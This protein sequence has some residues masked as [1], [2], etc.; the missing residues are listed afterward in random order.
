MRITV[1]GAG[2]MGVA[3]AYDL[4]Q[5]SDITSVVLA[6]NDL[7]RLGNAKVFLKNPNLETIVA[8]ASSRSLA[9]PAIQFSDVVLSCAPYKYNYELAN[10]A[11]QA[12][13]S[14]VD[15]GGNNDIVAKEL[16]L[17]GRAKEAGVIIIPDCGLAPGLVSILTRA[18]VDELDEVKEVHLRVGGLPQNPRGPLAYALT[19]SISGL[20][21]EYIEPVVVL[22]D[23]V[24]TI[25]DPLED[26][27]HLSI[28]GYHQLE[29]FNTSGGISTLPD[30]FEGKISELDYKTIRY[31]GHVRRI[32][33]LFE[34]GLF[35]SEKMEGLGAYN[36]P[37]QFM[38]DWLVRTLPKNKEDIIL[39]KAW[40]VGMKN[41][42]KTT[43][44]YEM[45][46]DDDKETGLTAM[47]RTTSFT[48]A[49]IVQLI[50]KGE[51]TSKGAI[52]QELCVP[53]QRVID[54]LAK[55]G[56]KI[57]KFIEQ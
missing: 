26:E 43:I 2:Q 15:L 21:N 49:T 17:N 7:Q 51:I 42:R 16:E 34:L 37:R 33:T 30:T 22:R 35:D 10:A 41:G 28:K 19:F 32:K 27:E 56:I 36:N 4:L 3:A 5:D 20:I 44:T 48:A 14:F 50:A 18:F 24:K 46:D 38:E 31:L 29:A 6:D 40:A 57:E 45:E 23:G 39:L 54:E 1:F 9:L 12:K 8:D 11:I 25:V 13:V 47:M 52:P 53:P 55:K